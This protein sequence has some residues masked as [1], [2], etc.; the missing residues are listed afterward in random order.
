[1]IKKKN[2]PIT[3]ILL[4]GGKSSRIGL[5]KDKGKMKLLGVNLVDRVI[6]NI[7]TIEGF[8]KENIVIVGPKDKYSDCNRVVEDI[9]PGKGPLGGIFTGLQASDTPYNLVIGCDMPFIEGA[10]IQ[11]MIKN[12]HGHD[13]I[14]PSYKKGLLEPLCALYSKNCLQIIEKNIK[15]GKLAVRDIFPFLKI[16][17]I[18]EDEIKKFDPG[19]YS[20][21]NINFKRDFARAEELERR[22]N[23][24][25]VK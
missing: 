24:N 23:K 21:F 5:N 16:R 9:Y 19:L 6:N 4:A 2:F 11:H 15:M 10:L 3:V 7:T 25:I 8:S 17:L 14:I 1:M 22:R 12:I 13:I 18:T 20:F